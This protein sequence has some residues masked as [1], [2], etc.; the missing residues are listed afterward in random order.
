MTWE[1]PDSAVY[2]VTAANL[3]A[4]FRD[5]SSALGIKVAPAGLAFANALS[6]RPHLALYSQDGHPT[7]DG[8]Y[9]A[10][11]VVYGTVFGRSPVGIAYADAGISHD[12]RDFLQRIAAESLGY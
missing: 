11:C 7:V 6:E 2:G 8:T 3:A 5:V 12:V 10:A 4:T 9:L 1:R